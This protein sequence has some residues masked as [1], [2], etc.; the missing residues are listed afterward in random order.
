MSRLFCTVALVLALFCGCGGEP[1][2]TDTEFPAATAPDPGDAAEK[3]ETRR[4]TTA[5]VRVTDLQGR[6]L[7]NMLPIATDRPNAFQEPAAQGE[8]TGADGTSVLYLPH[9]QHLY[10]RAWDPALRV[11]P[12]NFYEVLPAS[13][14]ET[15]PMT[16][17][18]AE[19]A[20]LVMTLLD[21]DH[22]PAANENTGLMLFHDVYGPWWP[23]EADTD[24][25]GRVVFE[26][27]PPGEFSLKVMAVSS[28]QL[29]LG[30]VRLR[31]G[32]TTDLGPVVLQ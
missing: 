19:C 15:A 23:A 29:E 2:P 30:T 32:G 11:F 12:N 4:V 18:M 16:V 5:R 20:T 14:S 31:P 1:A 8:L 27:V 10:V 26:P 28:G 3:T 9:G 21:G 22:L 17:T 13:G 24:A 6:P 7:A 25:Q